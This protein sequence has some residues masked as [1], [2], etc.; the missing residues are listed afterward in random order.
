[1]EET[2][3][4]NRCRGDGVASASAR[5]SADGSGL[6]TVTTVTLTVSA[7]RTTTATLQCRAQD[8]RLLADALAAAANRLRS[9][10]PVL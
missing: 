3:H 10:S 8:V 5:L 6:D 9:V 1:M 7:D 2:K 4:G